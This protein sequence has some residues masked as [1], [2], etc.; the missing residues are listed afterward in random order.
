MDGQRFLIN[1]VSHLIAGTLFYS[2]VTWVNDTVSNLLLSYI[3]FI[4]GFFILAIGSQLLLNRNNDKAKKI[5]QPQSLAM[6]GFP[7]AILVMLLIN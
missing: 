5:F 4:V 2:W 7:V 1:F 6:I 3:L